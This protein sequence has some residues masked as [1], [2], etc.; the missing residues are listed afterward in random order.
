MSMDR[1]VSRETV[2][3]LYPS[4]VDRPDDEWDVKIIPSEEMKIEDINRDEVDWYISTNYYGASVLNTPHVFIA[5]VDTCEDIIGNIFSK[6]MTKNGYLVFFKKN[7]I[8]TGR[9]DFR[10]YETAAGFRIFRVD[11][12]MDPTGEESQQ[13]MKDMKSDVLYASCCVSQATYRARLSPK[14]SRIN[15]CDPASGAGFDAWFDEYYK[16]IRNFAVCD[17]IISQEN[18][19][20]DEGIKTVILEHDNE[21][22][23]DGCELA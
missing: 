14:P 20:S 9:G 21:C 23:N 10:V 5:D 18:E 16:R 7:F 22:F 15:M 4:H 19:I 17:L 2:T 3:A 8:N 11:V 13:L 6:K 12:Q 1:D